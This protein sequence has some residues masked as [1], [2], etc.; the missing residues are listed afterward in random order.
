MGTETNLVHV[1]PPLVL[2][3]KET[4]TNKSDGNYVK[5]KLRIDPTS[6]TL[7]LY[8][9]TMSLFDHGKPEEF[10]LFV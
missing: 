10:L 9:F 3:V 5:L 8:E 7:Y 4:P 6:S 1:E 2:L